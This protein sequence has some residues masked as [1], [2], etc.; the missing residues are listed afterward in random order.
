MK[1]IFFVSLSVIGMSMEIFGQKDSN[2]KLPDTWT[3]DFTIELNLSGNRDGSYSKMKFTYTSCE[4][5]I[6]KRN[7]TRS[8]KGTKALT[9]NDRNQ[10]LKF[11]KKNKVETFTSEQ[12]PVRDGY[13]SSVCFQPGF[14][15]EGGTGTEMSKENKTLFNTVYAYLSSFPNR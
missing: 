2:Q 6:Y 13:R 12:M 8:N 1:T 7:A 9:E 4:Y 3:E 11:L 10:I 5:D 15:M 14:C